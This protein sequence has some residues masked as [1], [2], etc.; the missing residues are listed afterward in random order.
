M[1]ATILA[2]AAA[3]ILGTSQAQT[4]EVQFHDVF[5]DRASGYA[6]V[7]T[8]SGWKHVKKFDPESLSRLPPA[9]LR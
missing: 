4:P 6:F 2:A 7:A 8:A 1:I 3:F 5:V 9:L